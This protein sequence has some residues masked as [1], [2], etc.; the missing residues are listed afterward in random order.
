MNCEQCQELIHDLVDGS[1]SHLDE[2]TL[3]THLKQCLDCD[4][5]RQDLTSILSFCQTHRG[6]YEAPPNEQALWL[7]IRNVI[8]AETGSHAQTAAREPSFL[9]RLMGRTWEL[10]LPQL[11]SLAAAIVLLVS[12][13]TVVGLRRWDGDGSVPN[14]VP[15]AQAS[16]INDRIW[17][18]RQVINYW[19]QR[20]ELNKTRWSPEMRE[21][22][23]RNLKVIDEAVANSL[24]ELNQNPH[25]EV[26][27]Q[28]LNESLNDKLA[29]LKEFSDL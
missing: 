3:N 10:S 21:T 9:G 19:N 5:V 24:N 23:D 2:L 16:N 20:V 1:L 26:S 15:Q 7:R 8:E 12:L 4:S 29:L 13:T 27:E 22:F 18:R 25:D 14:V 11:A 6:E 17:Q 28:M